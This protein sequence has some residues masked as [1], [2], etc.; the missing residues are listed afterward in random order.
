MSGKDDHT[1][2][3]NVNGNT[4]FRCTVCGTVEESIGTIH[5]HVEKHR[6][7]TRFGIQIPF[8]KTSPGNADELMKKTEKIKTVAKASIRSDSHK[9]K[10][11]YENA[12]PIVLAEEC[13]RYEL[14]RV[15]SQMYDKAENGV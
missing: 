12:P 5:A 8:T 6:G 3:Q 11:E 14:V 13:G 2:S 7:Y 4:L 15:E 10:K 1:S 9:I